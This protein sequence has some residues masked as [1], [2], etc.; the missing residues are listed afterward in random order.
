MNWFTASLIA[1]VTYAIGS[2]IGKYVSNDTSEPIHTGVLTVIFCSIFGFISAWV[3]GGIQ[4]SFGQREIITLVVSGLFW[5]LGNFAFYKALKI[6]DIS[7]FGL[8]TRLTVVIQVIGGIFFFHEVIRSWQT[9]GI[10]F[11]GIGILILSMKEW[12]VRFSS[13]NILAGIS[14]ILFGIGSLID[15][16]LVQHTSPS[17]YTGL[18]YFVI[19]LMMIPSSLHT[20]YI[21]QISFPSRRSVG[22][23]ALSSLLYTVSGIAMYYVFQIGTI[24]LL[25]VIMQIEIPILVFWGILVLGEREKIVQK[26]IAMVLVIIGT[27]LLQ[28]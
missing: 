14:A 5:A 26:C 24:S 11:V 1:T 16:L 15:K 21:K 19:T 9:V 12:K 10:V 13:G 2:I 28:R 7:E 18:L 4:I 23:I 25:G 22:F 6:S 17:L 20:R 3:L 8:F 27:Y